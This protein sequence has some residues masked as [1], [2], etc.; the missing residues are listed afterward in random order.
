MRKKLK[1]KITKDDERVLRF[2]KKYKI[3]K[4]EDCSL[5]YKS[6]RY[7][8]FRINMLIDNGYVK[9]Y[10]K[11]IVLDKNGRKYL[12]IVGENYIKNID[13]TSFVERLKMIGRIAA[14]TIDTNMV[15]YPSW[16]LKEK[17]KFTESSRKYL[18][19]LNMNNEDYYIYYISKKKVH[20]YIKQI[21]FD[22]KKL[23][24]N[25]NVV[26]ILDDYKLINKNYSYLNFDKKNTYI[27]LNNDKTRDIVRN[28]NNFDFYSE[29][30]KRY[31]NEILMSNWM[32]ADYMVDNT[33]ILKMLFLNTQI[34][35]NLNW[36]YTENE[37]NYKTLDIFTLNDNKEIINELLN[38]KCNIITFDINDLLGGKN[39]EF[40]ESKEIT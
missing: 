4:V 31:K 16:E 32:Y 25:T 30:E 1:E 34:I 37:Y 23:K 9:K 20:V 14:L 28:Y 12:N 33:N 5:I 11:Y 29:I 27:V 3:M 19:V 13:N 38:N 40:E 35:R 2:L 21:M 6:K 8:R 17:G 39:I 36:Y 15:F 18:G 24:D 7:Y 26:I 10:K 22:I